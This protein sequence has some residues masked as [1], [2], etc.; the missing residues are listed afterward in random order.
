MSKLQLGLN[1]ITIEDVALVARGNC[2]VTLAPEICAQIQASRAFVDQAVQTGEAIYGISTGFGALQSVSIAAKDL[3][4]LQHNLLI[5]HAVSTGENLPPEIVRSMLVLR[6]ASLSH[7]R[8]GVRL[9]LIERILKLIELDMLPEIPRLGSVGAS[10]DLSPLS[11]MALPLIGEGI[12]LWRGKR[13]KSADALREAGLEPLRLKAKE[14]LALNNGTQFM[15]ACASYLLYHAGLLTRAADIA[16]AMCLEVFQGKSSPFEACVHEVRPHPGQALAAANLRRLIEGSTLV[17]AQDPDHRRVQ[18]SYSIRCAPQVHGASRDTL[19]FVRSVCEREINS[20]T[21]NPL[22]YHED[23]RVISAGN[24]HGEPIAQALDCAKIALSELASIS[25]RR[26]AKMLD[27]AQSYGLP[28]F[29]AAA[30]GINSGLMIVQYTSAAI[31]SKNKTL[32]HPDSVDSISTSANQEDHVSMGANSALHALEILEN[33]R[34]VL[35]IEILCARYARGF[36]NGTSGRG[37]GVVFDS[38]E[39]KLGRPSEVDHDF[40]VEYHE[41]RE[42]LRDGSL[43][44]TVEGVLGKLD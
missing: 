41:I 44:S 13:W 27:P 16:L 32:A 9:E 26:T 17:D 1:P 37:T 42:M 31:V 22:V 30:S 33:L 25:E 34:T 10:G 12:V 19:A 21:D 28:P 14:G 3:E 7:G 40:R 39:D 15:S 23:G 29:L 36:R 43:L 35:A 11:H 24:F 18:D 6:A 20:V 38:L 4:Q 8:S 5:S 2:C